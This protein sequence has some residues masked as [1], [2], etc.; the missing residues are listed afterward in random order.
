MR[1]VLV[2]GGVVAA[3]IGF[4]VWQHQ[5]DE[6]P[7]PPY[8]T[9]VSDFQY[10]D[11]DI[12]NQS[13]TIQLE[14]D[15]QHLLTDTQNADTFDAT[16]SVLDDPTAGHQ[17]SDFVSNTQTG[18]GDCVNGIKNSDEQQYLRASGEL[19]AGLAPLLKLQRSHG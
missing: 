18:A 16:P 9:L 5:K 6:K 3:V 17:W 7:P 13:G 2:V 14:A 4:L 19:N 1:K 8:N 11:N 15:C 10:I 12:T